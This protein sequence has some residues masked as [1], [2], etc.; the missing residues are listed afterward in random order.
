M[1][2][3]RTVEQHLVEGLRRIGILCMKFHPDSMRGM[4]DRMILLPDSRVIWCELKTKGGKL[5][6]IQLV[7][8]RELRKAGHQVEV[9]WSVEQ[10]DKLIEE[11]ETALQS[12][13]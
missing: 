12:E 7:R 6:P 3:E 2:R 8:H 13:N 9:V 4:P 1:V 11:I 5:E 10:A